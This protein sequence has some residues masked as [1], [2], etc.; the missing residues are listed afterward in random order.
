M[1][2]QNTMIP[3]VGALALAAALGLKAG[4]EGADPVETDEADED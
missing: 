1:N 4:A 2:R 3:V